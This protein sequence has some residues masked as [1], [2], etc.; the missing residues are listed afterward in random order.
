MF[1]YHLYR[2]AFKVDKI[3]EY[4]TLAKVSEAAD[5]LHKRDGA[6]YIIYRGQEGAPIYDPYLKEV[7][8]YD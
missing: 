1:V 8:T 7:I 6:K 3:G 4:K 5:E 2:V